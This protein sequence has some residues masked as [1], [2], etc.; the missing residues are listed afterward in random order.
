MN[1]LKRYII[2]SLIEKDKTKKKDEV[3]DSLKKY[4]GQISSNPAGDRH[5]I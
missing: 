2:E 1:I 3:K 5:E 4:L